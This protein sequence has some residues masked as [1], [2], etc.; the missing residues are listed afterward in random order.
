MSRD[1]RE[2]YDRFLTAVVVGFERR[3]YTVGE[4]DGQVELCVNVTVPRRQDIGIVSFNLTVETQNGSAGISYSKSQNAIY[5]TLSGG[6][7]YNL[8]HS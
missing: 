6:M 4:G 7:L 5:F 1:I 3:T 2:Y 8:P